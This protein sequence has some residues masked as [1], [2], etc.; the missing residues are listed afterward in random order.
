MKRFKLLTTA[1][2][3]STS[4]VASAVSVDEI[5]TTYHENIGGVDALKQLKGI[6][7]K[8]NFQQGQ[9]QF[10]I[11]IVN[12]N[13]GK[14]YTKF[15]VQGK[16]LKQSVYDG[17]T[18]WSVNFM[19]MKP[20]KST[21]E[22]TYNFSL[23]T[24]DFPDALMDYK[25]KGYSAELVGTESVEGADA[26]KIKLTQE[27]M[28]V[29]GKET[30]NV[31]YYYFDT[32]SMVL[33]MVENE[34]QSGPMKGATQLMKFSDYQEVDSIYFPFAIMQEIKGQ[35]G[36]PITFESIELNPTVDNAAFAFPALPAPA[37]SA[38]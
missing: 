2:L 31:S 25:A 32:D 37:P 38:E 14:T 15:S 13:S 6:K 12:L 9:M 1:A 11:E 16:E 24:N 26:H 4:F 34:I 22:D 29:D 5:I 30:P 35:G 27:P 7:M 10:P 18:L 8:G 19:T 21:A 28:K 17:E 23:N 3:L 33:V 20:E 36:A